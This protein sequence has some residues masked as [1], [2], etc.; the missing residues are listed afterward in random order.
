MHR[1]MALGALLA[2]WAAVLAVV[3]STVFGAGRSSAADPGAGEE[4]PSGNG[5]EIS[6]AWAGDITPGSRYGLPPEDGRA[7]SRDVREEPGERGSRDRESGGHARRSAGSRSAE[8]TAAAASASRRRPR[9]S[10][11]SLGRL[12]R[13]EPRQQPRLRL[14][15]GRPAAD[16]RRAA[17]QGLRPHGHARADHGGAPARSS[18]RDWSASRPTRGQP[19]CATWPASTQ[20]VRRAAT[21]ADARGGARAPRRRG[22]R[23]ATHMPIGVE[24]RDR[25][26]PR[27]H[28]R[29]RA[30]RD[31]CRRRP[32]ARLRPA[33]PARHG[34]LRR[35]AD[36][37]LARQLRRLAQLL[38]R[39][40]PR[41]S[42][43]LDCAGVARRRTCEAAGS[44]A[45]ASPPTASPQ[46]TR[47]G[48]P[49]LSSTSSAGRTSGVE[50][51][52][53]WPTD[54]SRQRRAFAGM[55]APWPPRPVRAERPARPHHRRSARHRRR[56]RRA[57]RVSRRAARPRRARAR[58]DGGGR[59]TCGEG[60]FVAECDV[61]SSDEVA[62]AVDAA[63]EALGGLDVVVANAGIA[64]GGPL[65]TR[66]CA[67]GSG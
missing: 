17:A 52:G 50:R 2:G 7:C 55:V 40:A 61:S 16:H 32:R 45:C 44:R 42:G 35:Q 58:D 41:L 57:A 23:P 56:A 49:S 13:R 36:R 33:R 43:L 27:R 62:Q 67:R 65:R 60:T 53:C 48:R 54:R 9:T 12:R 29:L 19:T 5:V 63:A 38:D 64:T 34:A 1:R 26:G 31:R 18:H 66:T 11:R 22:H 3:V 21:A 25:R 39:R 24:Y 59:A 4:Q 6:I 15:R 14:R 37:L 47:P 30:R 46:R 8:P 28:P 10:R 20:L 51:F